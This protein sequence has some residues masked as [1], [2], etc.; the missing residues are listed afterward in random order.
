MTYLDFYEKP[1]D[2]N[3]DKKKKSRCPRSNSSNN[4]QQ[5]KMNYSVVEKCYTVHSQDHS[6]VHSPDYG[7]KRLNI[8]SKQSVKQ[9]GKTKKRLPGK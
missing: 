8:K 7:N 2:K 9:K 5:I 3:K 1:K 6:K 4:R